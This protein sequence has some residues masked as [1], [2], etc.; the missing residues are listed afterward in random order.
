MLSGVSYV[1][2]LCE[3]NRIPISHAEMACG[4]SNGYLN[5]KKLSKIPYQKALD[6]LNFFS[7]Q[8]IPADINAI[9]GIS[10]AVCLTPKDER[11]ISKDVE[12]IL[13]KLSAGE[14]GPASYNGRELDPEA[15]E[16]FKDELEI[17]LRR[18]KLINKQKY[19]P[20]KYKNRNI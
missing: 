7:S 12:N 2:E 8:N 3:K 1:R 13:R 20:K 17:A 9:M 15:A 14:S 5:P 18:L 10:S 16:L 11:D 19:T 6:L 4:F